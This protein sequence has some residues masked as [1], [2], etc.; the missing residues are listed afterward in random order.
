MYEHQEQLLTGVKFWNQKDEV[1]LQTRAFRDK[2][3][4]KE[5]DT[6]FQEIE[7]Q[8]GERLLGIKSSGRGLDMA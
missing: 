2:Q 3:L 4:V 8:E 5:Q 6:R 1:I 7:L